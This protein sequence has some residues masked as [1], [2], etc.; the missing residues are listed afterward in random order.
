MVTFIWEYSMKNLKKDKIRKV[1][2]CKNCGKV[3]FQRPSK[4]KIIERR[5]ETISGHFFGPI[6]W[7]P[8]VG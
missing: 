6:R 8:P 5:G 2:I 3:T 1:W 4:S 7:Y